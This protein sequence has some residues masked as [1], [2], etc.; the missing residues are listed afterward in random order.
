MKRLFKIMMLFLAAAFAG[1]NATGQANASLNILTL[2][3]GQV[4][5]GG[6]VDIQV[7]VGNTGP[8]SIAAFKVRAQISVPIAIVN[9]LTPASNQTGLPPG[10]TIT[11]LNAGSIIIC[12]GTD[13]IPAGTQ[14]QI[15]VKMQGIAIGGP[16]TIN[17]SLLFSNGSSCNV[18][19]TL[20]GDNTAD[21]TGTTSIQ[22]ISAPTCSLTGVSASAGTIACNGGTTSII[23]T[24]TTTGAVALEYNLN[25]GVFQ[26]SNTFVVPGG[27]YTVTA[28]EVNTPACSATTPAITVSEP[29]AVA[30]PLIG[31]ITQPTCTTATGSVD[32]SGLPSGNWTINPG[33]ITGNTAVATINNLAPGTYN[34]TVTNTA[35]CTSPA[36][37]NVV[38]NVQP[39]TPSAPV[40]GT[41]TQPTCAVST[42]S[43]ALSG[44]PPGNWIINPGAISGNTATTTISG[45]ASG[46]YNF[47][48][49]NDAGCTSTGSADVVINDVPGAPPSP[50]INLVQPT[51]TSATGIITITSATSG[52]TFSLDGGVYTVYPTGGYVVAA[53]S[54]TLIAQNVSFCTSPFTN[55][56][57]NAQPATP[58]APSVNAAQPTCIATGTITITSTTAGLTFSL[59]GGVYADYP[60]GGYIAATGPHT[61]TAQNA[62]GCISSVTN[63]TVNAQP[64][65]PTATASAGVIACNGGTT[66]LTVTE[67]NGTAPFQYS[68]NG[69]TFQSGNTFTTGAGTYT[70]TV[71]DANL[72]TVTTTS[73]TITQPTAITASVSSGAIAC[74]NGTTTLIV[75]TTGG[76]APLQYSLNGGTFQL[77][78]SFTTGAGIY[79]ITVRDANLCTKTTTPVTITQPVALTASITAKRITQCGGTSEVKVAATGGTAPYTSGVGTFSKGPGTWIFTVADSG[80]CTDSAAITIEA[81]GCVDLKVFPNPTRGMISI[82]HST[83][84][85]GSVMQVFDIIGRLVITKPV[86]QNAFL[87]TIDVSKLAAGTYAVVYLNGSDKKETL[88]VKVSTN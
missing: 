55:I 59:D 33:A 45:L 78:N 63:I 52:L 21:N 72:C 29:P 30:A 61:L 42:G 87:T 31:A 67:S 47:T 57:V 37:A 22:V 39:I 85:Q 48:V 32:L 23:A 34:F 77:S 83:A 73:L 25:G 74:N 17:G 9:L 7:T 75:A 66:T 10:W 79:T 53:G 5:V 82:N 36:S 35:G 69:G 44:L 4:F 88:F 80:G 71:R 76:I 65:P 81:P 49:T 11:V 68:L 84:A 12:N 46:T 43:V 40:V 62:S 38:I 26:S 60:A 15:F 20:A 3:S 19:G 86:P 41:I 24:A 6:T 18:T 14:R 51:C 16:S 70:V 27:T 64:P 56:T 8:N 28:R 1:L 50:A 13:V 54:H 2:N 58:S